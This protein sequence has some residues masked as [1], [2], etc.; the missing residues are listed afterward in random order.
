MKLPLQLLLSLH[1]LRHQRQSS[2]LNP[3]QKRYN[4]L[5]PLLGLVSRHPLLLLRSALNPK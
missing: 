5:L 1:L 4:R 2:H 3:L